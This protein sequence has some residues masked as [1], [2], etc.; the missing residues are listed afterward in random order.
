M[1]TAAQRGSLRAAL[2]DRAAQDNRL[3]A[4]AITG[5]AAAGTEDEYSDIDLAFAVRDVAQ[6]PAVLEDWTREMYA[7]QD[8]VAHTD[9]HAGPWIYRVFLLAD[10]LQVDLAFVPAGDF[11][12]L[13]PTF[14]LVFGEAR[15]AQS[16]PPPAARNLIGMAWLHALHGRSAIAR[17][18]L[19]Q[20]LH[21]IE[22]TR[23]HA[24]MLACVRHGVTAY[25]GKGIDQLPEAVRARFEATLP[26]SLAPDDLRDAFAAVIGVLAEEVAIADPE[27]AAGLEPALRSLLLE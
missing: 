9:V 3:A 12:P 27:L 23:N 10:T 16:F 4:A 18:K 20:A 17:G 26:G 6:M 1:F 11:R 19:W 21:M 14:Q 22:G 15:E 24:L 2:L 25:H 5:S 13:A 7:N 8:A